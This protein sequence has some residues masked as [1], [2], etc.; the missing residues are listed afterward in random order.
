[1]KKIA[2]ASAAMGGAALL[3]FGASGTFAAFSDSEQ[4]TAAAGAGELVL[5]T[6]GQAA[7][8]AAEATN[9]QP[10]RSATYAYFL[11]NGGTLDG[12][13]TATT[14][15]TD[16]ENG[17][18]SDSE[19]EAEQAVRGVAGA[20][21]DGR[22]GAADSKGEFSAAAIMSYAIGN[23]EFSRQCTADT[24]VR[25]ELEAGSM[26]ALAGRTVPIADVA[27][28]TGVCVLV[29]VALP[30]GVGNEVQGDTADFA[31]EF[32]IEQEL[33]SLPEL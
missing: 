26:R 28:Q 23:A 1:M 2:I 7:T 32:V 16:A 29:E 13:L 22:C 31:V 17:C 24:A 21:S 10:G 4:Q 3:A 9:L 20:P 12:A 25:E 15:V 5:R 18:S 27:A 8:P 14:S 11:R 33:D 6:V 19:R 30:A